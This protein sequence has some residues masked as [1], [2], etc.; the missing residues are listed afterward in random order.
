MSG[1][2]TV[3]SFA[4]V[5]QPSDGYEDQSPAILALVTFKGSQNVW[6]IYLLTA[7]ASS[8]W[9]FDTPARQ[10]LMPA[11]VPVKDFP[12]AVSIS[13]LMFQ[14]GTIIGPSLS[15]LVLAKWGPELVYAI[16]AA[17]FLA[18]IVGTIVIA[19]FMPMIGIITGMSQQTQ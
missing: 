7:I 9:A 18:V 12:N 17:S 16:N 10:S 6:P 4:V 5:R 13:M 8:A 15:G 19:L 2:G 3:Y 11:L 1:A 14:M